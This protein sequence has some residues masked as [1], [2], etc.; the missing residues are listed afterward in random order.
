MTN[1]SWQAKKKKKGD[2]W[3]DCRKLE[4]PIFSGVDV[5]GWIY[6]AERY[7]EIHKFEKKDQ[8]RAVAICLE[9]A[10]LT[11]FRWND[12]KKPFRSWAGFKRRLLERFQASRE[13]SI[14]E[15]FLNIQQ[16]GTVR[17]YVDRFEGFAGQLSNIPESIQESTFIK[18]LKE[19]IRAAVRIAEPGSLGQ[20][21]RMAIK[22]DENKVTG[23]TRGA[24]NSSRTG[25]GYQGKANRTAT[26]RDDDDTGRCEEE[27]DDTGHAHCDMAQV[28]NEPTLVVTD[29]GSVGVKLGNRV[30]AWSYG[31]CKGVFLN[32]PEAEA[33]LQVKAVLEAFSD[34][35]KM[36]VGLPPIRSQN[37]A[38]TLKDGIIQP[39]T[40]PFSSP[41]LLV[42]KKDGSWRFCIDY[43]ALNKATVLDKF[44]IPVIDEL[45]DELHGSTIFSKLDLKSGY[46][47]IRMKEE[48]THK[49]AFRTHEDH[50]EFLVMPFGLTNAPVTFQSL[51]N[52]V[53]R[54]FL[55]RFVLVFFDDILVYS[56]TN[57]EHV[58]HLSEV[59]RIMREHKLV[60]NQKKCAFA[61]N[62]I[63]YLGH[64]V[65][66]EGVSA[67]PT[68]SNYAQKLTNQRL[69]IQCY[70]TFEGHTCEDPSSKWLSKLLGCNFDIEYQPRRENNAADALSR[71]TITELAAIET[72]CNIDWGKLWQEIDNDPELAD[73]RR[74][75]SIGQQ[76]PARYSVDNNRLLFKGRLVL[77]CNSTWVPKLFHE[78]H[79]STLGGHSGVQ[80][81][82]RRMT[83]E[84]FWIGMKGDISKMV[85]QCDVCQRHK[86]STMAPSGLLQPLELPNKVWSEITMDF[87]TGLPKSKGQ[88]T[89]VGTVEEYLEERDVVL[90]DLEEYL[91][92]AQQLMKANAVKHRKDEEFTVGE[93]VFLKLQPY[94]QHSVARRVNEKLSPRYFG[95]FE[96]LERIGRVAYRLKLPDSSKIHDVFHISQLKKA[97]GN[98][99][100]LPSLPAT[101]TADMEVLLQPEQVEG[102]REGMSGREVLI[103]WKDLPM[104][105]ATWERFEDMVLQFPDF[106]LEDKVNVWEGSNDTTQTSQFG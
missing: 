43:R 34:I 82:Y 24:N 30:M 31:C 87:I 79:G 97:I 86:Y 66:A 8:L 88:R 64:L 104:Y 65:S 56:K 59:L 75:V 103:R 69:H 83:R 72:G 63:E 7:F 13:G 92:R 35:F 76:V 80:K 54:S 81:T 20:A 42:K 73:L 90:R 5:H 51:M 50:Y 95:P 100:A 48:D 1:K 21:I 93:C 89:S 101:L 9:G 62:Q 85:S 58:D 44:P 52:Q 45:L 14:Q 41:V 105:E 3:R 17:E 67:D 22:I 2:P 106:H 33:P 23:L 84:L 91:M 6:K 18:G 60:A 68:V 16:T 36:L 74:R 71:K 32:L 26:F 38:I 53:L 99:L 70:K 49:T 19:E 96:V 57:E 37:H 10:P 15:Q 78:F 102:V 39:S 47:Q 40:S 28:V 29:T 11:W 61:Q 27:I 46:H 98:H 25:Y 55:R 94:R 77:N 4:I 12:A